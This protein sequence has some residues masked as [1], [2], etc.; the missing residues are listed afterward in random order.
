MSEN[1]Y[2][3]AIIYN[4]NE[5]TKEGQ[6]KN[7]NKI[8]WKENGNNSIEEDLKIARTILK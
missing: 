7:K 8:K 6:R 3:D 1:W 2:T 4:N 5:M